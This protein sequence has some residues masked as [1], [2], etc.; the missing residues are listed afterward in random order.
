[1]TKRAGPG[2]PTWAIAVC[3]VPAA[4]LSAFLI[5]QVQPMVGKY[6]LPWFGGAPGVWTTCLLFFQ[7]L[8]LAGYA[9]AH[10]SVSRIRARWQAPIYVLLLL[11]ALT[12]SI[13]P[14]S[15]WKPQ[16]D[17]YP[18]LRIALMLLTSVGLPFLALS[19][20]GPLLQAWYA[21]LRP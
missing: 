18:L 5:F 1:M 14:E 12:A 8:L 20:S 16:G 10:L 6:I 19:A 21:R 2:G 4:F 15:T 11:V 17:E 9:Y 3:L 7:T 13:L